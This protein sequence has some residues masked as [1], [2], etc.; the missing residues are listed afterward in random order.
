[1]IK[2]L[3]ARQLV[4]AKPQAAQRRGF[5]LI[6]LMCVFALLAVLGVVT[7][8]LLKQTL[9]VERTQVRGFDR[10]LQTKTIADQ[11]RADVATAQEAPKA[12]REYVADEHTLILKMNAADHVVYVWNQE[13][14]TRKGS[15]NNPRPLAVDAQRLSVEFNQD[16]TDPKLITLRLRTMRDGKPAAGQTL[17]ITAALGGDWR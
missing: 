5:T 3:V 7:T 8:L 10:L 6:E 16:K 9:E 2:A 13:T 14:L 17:E 11:F 1:M 15:V 4:S 12:W